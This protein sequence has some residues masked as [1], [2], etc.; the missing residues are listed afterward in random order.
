MNIVQAAYNA[1]T[2]PTETLT[3]IIKNINIMS[4]IIDKK[5]RRVCFVGLE[6][7]NSGRRETQTEEYLCY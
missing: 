6:R 3:T 4:E 7:P 2:V 1:M 5:G